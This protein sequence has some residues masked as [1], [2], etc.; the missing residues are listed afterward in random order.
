M[1]AIVVEKSRKC[2]DFGATI[3]IFH[4]LFCSATRVRITVHYMPVFA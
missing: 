2:L 3:Y 4:L 1:L